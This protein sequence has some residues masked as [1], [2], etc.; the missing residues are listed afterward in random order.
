MEAARADG[1][2]T[3]YEL[4]PVEHLYTADALWLVSSG[5]GPVLITALDGR[6][7]RSDAGLAASIAA[8]AGF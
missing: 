8:Y 4:V 2:A 7:L 3:A 6:P 5:R 1:F